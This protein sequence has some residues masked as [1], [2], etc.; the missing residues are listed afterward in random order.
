MNV[1]PP[2][3]LL[4]ASIHQGNLEGVHR[5]NTT[6][7]GGGHAAFRDGDLHA[8]EVLGVQLVAPPACRLQGQKEPR[9]AQAVDIFLRYLAFC[10]GL[11][12]IL[13]EQ[14]LQGYDALQHFRPGSWCGDRVDFSG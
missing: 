4:R 2:Y 6:S 10:A 9:L 3:V 14:G 5:D 8:E 11:L 1:L 7:P 12:G 13:P